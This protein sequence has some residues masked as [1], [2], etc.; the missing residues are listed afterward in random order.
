MFDL[1]SR[2]EP[3]VG[4]DPI[5]RDVIW[6]ELRRLVDHEKITALIT[7]HYLAEAEKSDKVAF[8]RKGNC[9]NVIICRQS[10]GLT[11]C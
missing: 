4:I 11:V 5:I 1:F 3:T 6:K 9:D 7:T 2:D 10:P 8:M